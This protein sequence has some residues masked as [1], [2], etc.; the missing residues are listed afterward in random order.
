MSARSKARVLGRSLAR[1]LGTNPVEGTDVCLSLVSAVCGRV[2]VSASELITSPEESYRVW[3][4]CV[5]HRE[6]LTI[7]RPLSTGGVG[8]VTP[9]GETKKLKGANKNI[10][11]MKAQI[12]VSN[13]K[14]YYWKDI[15]K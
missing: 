8:A 5:C 3:C 2:E 14:T 15:T 11:K 9:W 10:T 6:A 13:G 1:I 4:V 12:Q 7:R